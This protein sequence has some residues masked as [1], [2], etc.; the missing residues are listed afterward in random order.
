MQFADEDE[1]RFPP[2]ETRGRACARHTLRV[3]GTYDVTFFPTTTP[4]T[5]KTRKIARK[6]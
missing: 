5:I 4:A 6:I 1:P 2:V 3:G